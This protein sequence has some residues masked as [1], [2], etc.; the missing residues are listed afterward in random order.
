VKL[1]KYLDELEIFHKDKMID[2]DPDAETEALLYNIFSV[3]A[4]RIGENVLRTKDI[5]KKIDIIK[6]KLN[7][8]LGIEEQVPAESKSTS[9]QPSSTRKKQLTPEQEAQLSEPKAKTGK[10]VSKSKPKS[11]A[12]KKRLTK[13][14]KEEMSKWPNV[15]YTD[16]LVL[17]LPLTPE[18]QQ[19]RRQGG[20]YFTR[21]ATIERE[22]LERVIKEHEE[23]LS[24]PKIA[25]EPKIK[26]ETNAAIENIEKRIANNE[27]RLK[28]IENPRQ[29][30][31]IQAAIDM[32]KKKLESLR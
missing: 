25:A 24:K 28:E 23:A 27:E 13:A 14:D 31:S 29:A 9:K 7:E 4:L 15:T 2:S 11:L 6:N 19:K 32:D 20:A 30:K 1:S 22:T 18:E 12:E 8:F 5:F 21:N 3:P 17:G 10:P 26:S 16:K